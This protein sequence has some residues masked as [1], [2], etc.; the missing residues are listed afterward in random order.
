M[1]TRELAVSFAAALPQRARSLT[2][3]ESLNSKDILALEKQQ[4][5]KKN[6]PQYDDGDNPLH[7]TSDRLS[8]PARHEWNWLWNTKEVSLERLSRTHS[9]LNL[10]EEA[11]HRVA[12]AAT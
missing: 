3:N 11:L 10:K 1:Q 12:V 7:L 9:P 5:K 4:Q 6:H 2:Q 8:I